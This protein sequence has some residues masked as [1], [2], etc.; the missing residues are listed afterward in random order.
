MESAMFEGVAMTKT[1]LQTASNIRSWSLISTSRLIWSRKLDPMAFFTS[2]E[3]MP[4]ALRVCVERHPK[5]EQF[6]TLRDQNKNTH[7]VVYRR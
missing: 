4:Y 5:Y 1:P 2:I 3:A 7:V 6:N